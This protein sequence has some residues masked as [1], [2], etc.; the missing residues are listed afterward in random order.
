MKGILIAL[1][2]IWVEPHKHGFCA[3]HLKANFQKAGFRDQRLTGLFY[4]AACAS[5]EVEYRK[6]REEIKTANAKAHNWI[7]R[8]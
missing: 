3:R 5:E 1:Q 6:L 2:E 4:A 7:E 8:S